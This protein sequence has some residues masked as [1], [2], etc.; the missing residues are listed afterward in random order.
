[1][2][3]SWGPEGLAILSG[4]LLALSFPKFGHGALAWVALAPLLVALHGAP[5]A[6]AFRLGYLAGAVSSLGI[7]Y[8]TALVVIQ[9]GGLSL[10]VGITVMG[11]LCAAVALF[12]SLFALVVARWSQTMGPGALLL[13]PLAWVGTEILRTHTFFNFP[14]CLLGYSQ[15]RHLP[16]IQIS[17][18]FAVY[19]VSFV[20]AM[21][22]ALLA[23][24]AVEG[25]SRRRRSAALALPLLL[26]AVWL[27]G[28]WVL[29]RPLPETGRIRVG[30]VQAGIRQE[31]KWEPE[32]AQENIGR[33]LELTEEA[34]LK[35]A[36]LVVWSESAVP[37]YFDRTPD[38]AAGLKALVRR[39]RIY[40]LFGNDD[41]EEE[42]GGGYRIWVGAKMLTPEGELALRYHKIRLVPFGEYVP[43][44]PLLTLGGRVAAKLVQQ[45]SDFTP[46]D[47]PVVARADGHLLGAFICYEAIFPDLVRGFSARG[48]DLL[49]NIT[50]DAWYGTTSAPYQH[51]AMAAFRAVE[52]GKYLVRA[53]NTGITA[54]IDPRGRVLEST[55]LFERTVLVR[56]VPLVPG[57]TFYSRHGD[58]FAWGCLGAAAGLTLVRRPRGGYNGRGRHH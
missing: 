26:G 21:S 33:H 54:V 46:G 23:Y 41:R 47:Q 27:E 16:F 13:S 45:V 1:L 40:L 57:Q 37:F 24:L 4:V 12:P 17:A 9:Y 58:V 39:H 50:N 29:S 42:P 18:L 44:Q 8:W 51:L 7:L 43:L 22:S 2:R 3:L 25:R 31:E 10:P 53:A 35:G 19:G 30:L 36:R 52:N 5:G 55:R 6:R 15:Y 48:A 11:L 34:A 38:L 56:D 20:V 49:V 14:W 32:Q 28:T